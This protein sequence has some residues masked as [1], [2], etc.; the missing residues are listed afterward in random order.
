MGLGLLPIHRDLS[1]TRL[2]KNGHGS[3]LKKVFLIFEKLRYIA[4]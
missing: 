2:H 1:L 3:G 4:N